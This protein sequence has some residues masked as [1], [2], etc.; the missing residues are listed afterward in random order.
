MSQLQRLP[1][2]YVRVQIACPMTSPRRTSLPTAQSARCAAWTHPTT[3]G[4]QGRGGAGRGGAGW[5]FRAGHCCTEIETEVWAGCSRA[6]RHACARLCPYGAD[7][8]AA[9]MPAAALVLDCNAACTLELGSL[10]A[11][12]AI[13]AEREEPLHQLATRWQQPCTACTAMRGSGLHCRP[14]PLLSLRAILFH[15]CACKVVVAVSADMIM[16]R[17]W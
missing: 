6:G 4:E 11:D 14:I 3:C 7:L 10:K 13:R 17:H 16:A 15:Q 5:A 1:S 9:P 12:A 2:C 8:C